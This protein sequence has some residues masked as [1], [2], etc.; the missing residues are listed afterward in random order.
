MITFFI[1]EHTCASRTKAKICGF[2][3]YI[4]GKSDPM[5]DALQIPEIE[6]G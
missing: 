3:L 2:C 6:G 4:P 1:H 5:T